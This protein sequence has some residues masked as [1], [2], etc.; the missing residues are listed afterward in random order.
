MPDAGTPW[1]WSDTVAIWT[2]PGIECQP[3]TIEVYSNADKVELLL[4]GHPM[5]RRPVGEEHRFRAE[6]DTAYEPSE[7]GAIAYRDGTE[8]G[9]RTLRSATGPVRLHADADRP[10]R[11]DVSGPG[12]P[13]RLRQRGPVHRGTLRR[14]RT[15]HP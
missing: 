6:F 8:T 13:G 4:N 14:H 7:L 12:Y 9:C 2:W 10:V 3:I 15:P 1:A 5:G 11:V